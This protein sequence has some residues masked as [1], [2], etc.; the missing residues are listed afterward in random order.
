MFCFMVYIVFRQSANTLIRILTSVA[1]Y[2]RQRIN[3]DWNKLW[4][5]AVNVRTQYSQQVF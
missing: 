5:V 2:T 1:K 4:I 3:N